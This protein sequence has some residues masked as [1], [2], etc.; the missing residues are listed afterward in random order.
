MVRTAGVTKKLGKIVKDVISYKPRTVAQV[1]MLPVATFLWL[2][3]WIAIDNKALQKL[4]QEFSKIKNR[5]DKEAF[6]AKHSNKF[7]HILYYLFMAGMIFGSA[8]LISPSKKKESEKEKPSKGNLSKISPTQTRKDILSKN[9]IS[10]GKTYKIETKEDFDKLYQE[11]MPFICLSMFPTETLN[12][13]TY[14]DNGKKTKNTIG[15]GSYWYP[16]NGDPKSSK[17]IKVS[18]HKGV[19]ANNFSISGNR[20]MDMVDAWARYR[21]GGRVYKKIQK[22][23]MGTELSINE[24]SAIFTCTYN[25]EKNGWLLCEFVKNNYQDPIKCASYLVDLPTYGFNGL[26]D[27]HCH[28]ALVY[29][30]LDNYIYFIPK[31]EIKGT[32]TSVTALETE[33]FY[34]MAEDLR[35]GKLDGARI[36]ANKIKKHVFK[37]GK[38]ISVIVNEKLGPE[39][40]KK[41]LNSPAAIMGGIMPFSADLG[42]DVNQVYKNGIKKYNDGDYVGAFL[43]FQKIIDNG[44][45]GADIRNDIAITYYHLGLYNKSIQESKRV[46]KMGE[47]DSY[48][49]ANFNAG[50]AYEKQ[51][52][53]DGAAINFKIAM[54]RNPEIG[55]YKKALDRVKQS[56]KEAMFNFQN[57]SKF[58]TQIINLMIKQAKPKITTQESQ[59]YKFPLGR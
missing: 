15:M 40:A 36:V 50:L 22:L 30:N 16:E 49:A 19:Q 12:L 33:E 20:A 32:G 52:N 38:Q 59:K 58:D 3:S 7:A 21:E 9:R 48:S 27:R 28:E 25:N 34:V 46:L 29:L 11:A 35:K 4:E 53:F 39:L 45:D 42:F 8:S 56:K 57:K 43:I 47:E 1:A 10:R 6:I 2:T 31:M 51:G 24:F 54:Q 17:W 55:A 37:N 26:L 14:S 18:K 23:L 41:I 13:G 5:K 44:Y